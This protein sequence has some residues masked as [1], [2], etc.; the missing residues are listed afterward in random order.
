MQKHLIGQR[1]KVRKKQRYSRVNYALRKRVLFSTYPQSFLC[2]IVYKGL[3]LRL[4]FRK[5]RRIVR[6]SFYKSVEVVA[7][8]AETGLVATPVFVHLDEELQ[9]Y[10]F[11]EKLL[12]IGAG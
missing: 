3:I 8:V 6:N 10:R 5:M 4:C 11:L 2:L 7:I 12:Y 1:E 9:E